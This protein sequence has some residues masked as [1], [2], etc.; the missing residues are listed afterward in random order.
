MNLSLVMLQSGQYHLV[1]R[2][3]Q[4][5]YLQLS[6]LI[7]ARYAYMIYDERFRKEKSKRFNTCLRCIA[8]ALT[9]S[10]G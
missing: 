4:R 6:V 2:R 7:S 9:E 5:G 8:Q 3:G 1:S 10:Q